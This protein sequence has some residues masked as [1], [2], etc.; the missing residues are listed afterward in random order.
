MHRIRFTDKHMRISK[1]YAVISVC[2]FCDM[3]TDKRMRISKTYAVHTVC[4]FC[5]MRTE[6]TAYVLLAVNRVVYWFRL[7]AKSAIFGCFGAVSACQNAEILVF[8]PIKPKFQPKLRDDLY[9]FRCFGNKTLSVDPYVLLIN[10]S[11]MID[12]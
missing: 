11:R 5:D 8:R 12:S 7:S 4:I 2:I 9:R 1:T 6:C 3:Q 10:S